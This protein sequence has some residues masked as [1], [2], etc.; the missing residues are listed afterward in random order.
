MFEDD[1]FCQYRTLRLSETL[2]TRWEDLGEGG[3]DDGD[4]C[5]FLHV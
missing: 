2:R 4:L 1:L 5:V 3:R